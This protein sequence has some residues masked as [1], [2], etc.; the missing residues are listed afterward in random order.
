MGYVQESM[1]RG[2]EIPANAF[3]KGRHGYH[4]FTADVK[5]SKIIKKP[6]KNINA[7]FCDE[8]G[9]CG[10]VYEQS[11]S[12]TSA[13]LEPVENFGGLHYVPLGNK[14][15]LESYIST[16][17]Y[18]PLGWRN[19]VVV[20]LFCGVGYQIVLFDPIFETSSGDEFI[21]GILLSLHYSDFF[22]NT[23]NY[24]EFVVTQNLPLIRLSELPANLYSEWA[25]PSGI[26]TKEGELYKI[27]KMVPLKKF[28]E[29]VYKN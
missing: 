25:I 14:L 4:L 21:A 13:I 28:K 1:A 16:R 2:A 5:S 7:D 12:A 24:Q 6:C 3:C 27:K 20:S 22:K 17:T 9:G 26:G 8:L 19:R 11:C 23:K 10:L 29:D 18:N 15:K